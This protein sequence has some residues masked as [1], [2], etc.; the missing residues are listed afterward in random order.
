MAD[1]AIKKKKRKAKKTKTVKQ[2]IKQKQSQ[3]QTVIVRIGDTEYKRQRR[4]RSSAPP[5]ALPSPSVYPTVVLQQP[6]YQGLTVSDMI[7]IMD[8]QNTRIRTNDVPNG[9]ATAERPPRFMEPIS[10]VVTGPRKSPEVLETPELLQRHGEAETRPASTK[11]ST[12]DEIPR[13]PLSSLQAGI[14]ASFSRRSQRLESIRS[15]EDRRLD[16]AQSEPSALETPAPQ[17]NR[18]APSDDEGAVADAAPAAPAARASRPPGRT[19][20]VRRADGSSTGILKVWNS[21]RN[22]WEDPPGLS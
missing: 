20:H 16:S 1:K 3:R 5:R 19:P 11:H 4:K 10:P 12:T 6:G 2:K 9:L 14:S 8:M 15:L 17:R 7:Q 13:M 18:F 21:T 22:E